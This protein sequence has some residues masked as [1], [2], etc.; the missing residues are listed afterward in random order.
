VFS[1]SGDKYVVE[2]D[3]TTGA[4]LPF[5]V[6][7]EHPAYAVCYIPE[8][9]VLC[10]GNSIGGIHVIDLREKKEIRYLLQHSNGI[11]DLAWDASRNQLLV[12]GGDGVLSAWSLPDF[13][14]LIALPLITEKLRQIGFAPDHSTFVVACGDGRIR[15]MD[16]VFFNE[17]SFES[18][19]PEG[20]TSA[21]FHP[22]KQAVLSGGKDAML[23]VHAL[24][25]GH[26]LLAIPAHN[27]AIYSIAFSPDGLLFATASRDKS[28]KLWDAVTLDP[29][30]KLDARNGGHSHAVNKLFWQDSGHLISCS[31]DRKILVIRAGKYPS[32][33]PE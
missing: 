8:H 29:V 11:Y 2:W 31:D 33:N 14:L 26:E 6:R 10:V 21:V 32:E 27:Y 23:R 12:A 1:A 5:A 15:L 28:I 22:L 24:Q 25:G 16:P 18:M 20:A 19:H 13:N 9:E 7:L 30:D 3:T 17:Q 4:Q